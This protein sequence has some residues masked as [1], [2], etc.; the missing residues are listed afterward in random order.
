[1]SGPADAASD[2]TA[3]GVP[4][5]AGAEQRRPVGY[6]AADIGGREPALLVQLLAAAGYEAVDWTLEQY[7]PLAQSPRRLVELVGLARG[8]GLAVAQLMVHLDYVTLDGELWEA[9]VSCS[10]RAVAAC[11][12]AGIGSVGVLSGPN[13][14]EPG[15]L[16]V[17]RDIAEEWAWELALAALQRVLA[18]GERAGVQV[19]LEPC[20]GTLAHGFYRAELALARLGGAAAINFDPSHHVLCG[21]DPAAAARAWGGRIEH[22]HLKDAVGRAGPGAGGFAGAAAVEGVDFA[23]L[24]PGEGAVDWP[25]LF[26]ALDAIGYTGAMSVENEARRLLEGPLRGD[27][28]RC[29]S[30][31]RELVGGLLDGRV[32]ATHGV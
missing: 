8:A 18:A 31:A 22:V 29:A 4:P 24:L 6:V 19:A 10:E 13:A 26:D 17:G 23:F 3:A 7:D 20:W 11:A 21:E 5:L 25:A 30:L 16:R 9:R 15:A 1:M 27:L 28:A 12:E 14:W 32:A 2:W